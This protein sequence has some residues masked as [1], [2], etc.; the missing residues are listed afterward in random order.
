MKAQLR[1]KERELLELKKRKLE[2]ELAATKKHIEEQE[3]QLNLKTASVAAPILPRP[4]YVSDPK[5][6]DFDYD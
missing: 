2:L 5:A 6:V 4:D 3:K 1:E